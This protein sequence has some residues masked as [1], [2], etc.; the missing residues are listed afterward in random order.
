MS[1]EASYRLSLSTHCLE[2]DIAAL[3]PDFG[4]GAAHDPGQADRPAASVI[5]V[6]SESSRRVA[7]SSVTRLVSPLRGADHDWSRRAVEPH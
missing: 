4:T 2:Q 5:S 1:T 3:R 7:P 6:V